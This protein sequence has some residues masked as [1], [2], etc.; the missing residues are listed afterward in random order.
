MRVFVLVLA[1][2]VI[3]VRSQRCLTEFNTYFDVA[4]T[5]KGYLVVGMCGSDPKLFVSTDETATKWENR[6]NFDVP[7]FSLLSSVTYGNGTY[8]LAGAVYKILIS[9]NAVNWTWIERLPDFKPYFFNLV[10]YLKVNETKSMFFAGNLN[11]NVKS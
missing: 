1:L 7:F 11:H 9:Q 6:S 3:Y 8:V 4:F 10:R 2:L 5:P